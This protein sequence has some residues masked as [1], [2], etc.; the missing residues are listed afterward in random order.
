M[1]DSSKVRSEAVKQNQILSGKTLT[2]ESDLVTEI[3]TEATKR[4]FDARYK[5]NEEHKRKEEHIWHMSQLREQ[6]TA[7]KYKKLTIRY[8]QF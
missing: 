5:L 2:T 4:I 8:M 7:D 3:E 1:L 6:A